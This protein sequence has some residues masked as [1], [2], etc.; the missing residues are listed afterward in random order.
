MTHKTRQSLFGKI[1]ENLS[2]YDYLGLRI[3]V[4]PPPNI[5][6][7]WYINVRTSN[8]SPN[9]V[10]Q[11]RLFFR[12]RTEEFEELVVSLLPRISMGYH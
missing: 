8:M 7:G 12:S 10:W 11:H 6:E 5:R 4:G 1:N 3:R 9:H 2:M